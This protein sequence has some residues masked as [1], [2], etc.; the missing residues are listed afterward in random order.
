MKKEVEDKWVMILGCLL[1]FCVQFIVNMVTVALPTISLDLDLSVKMV[2]AINLI[3]LI[4]SVSLMMPLGK[5]VIKYGIGK[6]LKISIILMIAGLLLSAFSTDINTLLFSRIIQGIA[7]ATINGSIYVLFTIELPP[8]RL[9]YDLGIMGSCGYIGL[10]LSNTVSGIIVY[11]ISWRAVFLV[12]IP[13]YIISLFILIKIDDEWHI[14]GDNGIDHIGSIIYVLFM[15]LLLYGIEQLDSKN[16]F[17]LILSII[18]LIIFF[19]Y[20]KNKKNPVCNLELLKNLK[21]V[22]GNYSAFV[23]YF[24]TFIA[25]Y[26]LNLYLQNALGYDARLT[27]TFLL[28]TPLAVVLISA[29]AGKLSDERDE[30]TISSIALTFILINVV[31]LFF[32]DCVPVYFLLI[33]CVLQGIGHGLFSSPNNRFVLTNIDQK[34]LSD[35]S[36]MLSTS[37]DVGKAMSLSLFSIICGFVLGGSNTLETNIPSFIISSKIMLGIVICFGISTIILLVLSRIKEPSFKSD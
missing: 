10:C 1:L 37:K 22:L 30:R 2:N 18:L 31:I 34:D 23:M 19:K 9:G 25:T 32:M 15:G 4:T 16:I 33:A 35:A 27:G 21:Y 28:A 36:P 29:F 26:I 17:I 3:F 8:N 12:L 24:M 11:Y 14:S 20:E 5:Y 7:T 6:S 13:I